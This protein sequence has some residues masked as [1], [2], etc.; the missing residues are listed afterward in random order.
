MCKQGQ[1]DCEPLEKGTRRKL[2]TI[3]G[4]GA[5]LGFIITSPFSIFLGAKGLILLAV[6]VMAIGFA[7]AT[8]PAFKTLE[9]LYADMK[10]NGIPRGAQVW[11]RGLQ[12]GFK[13]YI[14][15]S[16]YLIA[17]SVPLIVTGL[18]IIVLFSVLLLSPLFIGTSFVCGWYGVYAVADLI[19]KEN[20]ENDHAARHVAQN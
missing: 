13:V 1:P 4:A 9:T 18:T 17:C 15:S 7:I 5:A 16:V 2:Q 3:A 11:K 19:E 6:L 12:L 20:K 14:L 8:Y 10:E